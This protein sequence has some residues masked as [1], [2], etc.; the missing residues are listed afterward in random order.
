MNY[1]WQVAGDFVAGWTSVRVL[2]LLLALAGLVLLVRERRSSA[3]FAF[4]SI[5]APAVAFRLMRIGSGTAS[6]ESRHLIF[7]LPFFALTLALPLVRLAR[8]RV[9]LALPLAALVVISLGALEVAWGLHKTPLLYKGEQEARVAA[10]DAASSWLAATSRPDDLLFGY[11]PLFLG[12]W[13]RNHDFSSR[14]VPRADLK[15]ALHALYHEPKPLGRGVWVLDASDNNNF[16]PR[17]SI[18]LRLP[19]PA[20]AFEARTF[21]PFLVIRSRRPT[22]TIRE[23]L[24]ETQSVQ[25]VGKD[26]YI[27]DADINL[28][29]VDRALALRGLGGLGRR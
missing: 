10:R 19:Q 2:V 21:G 7:V 28:L 20:S 3:M 24:L 4:S 18:P 14:V 26:L 6:P 15:L 16:S 22:R 29:T 23:F 12:G 9:P 25:F 5:V 1:L 11:D 8:S 17:L 13:E 27:G